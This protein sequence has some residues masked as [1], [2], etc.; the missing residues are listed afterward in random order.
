MCNVNWPQERVDEVMVPLIRDLNERGAE[1]TQSTIGEFF[2]QEYVQT[3]K[4]LNTG[5]RLKAA[6]SKLSKRKKK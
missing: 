3:R 1:G 6:A 5:K 2:S 4:E